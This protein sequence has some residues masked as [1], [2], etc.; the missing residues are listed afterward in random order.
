MPRDWG[1]LAEN[2]EVAAALTAAGFE[3]DEAE[4][5]DWTPGERRRAVEAAEATIDR[6]LSGDE[7]EE[8]DRVA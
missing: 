4:A 5:G 2:L 8:S 7:E 1:E 6:E 3:V